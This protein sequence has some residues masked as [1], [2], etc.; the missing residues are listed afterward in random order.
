M[1]F[2]SRIRVKDDATGIGV[3]TRAITEGAETRHIQRIQLDSRINSPMERYRMSFDIAGTAA[4]G[5]GIAAFR[6]LSANPNVYIHRFAVGEYHAAVSSA[7]T[8]LFLK[9]ANSVASGSL[10]AATDIPKFD[11][12]AGNATLEVR[13]GAFTSTVVGNPIAVFN[14]TPTLAAGGGSM[15]S[16][17][18]ESGG[19]L[20]RA[21]KL[22]GDEG[23]VLYQYVA[24]DTDNRFLITVEWE[25]ES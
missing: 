5:A 18:F 11:T 10:I 21:I 17:G 24:G 8:P 1:P 7:V 23:L 13:F 25:E 6:K 9:R 22:T 15:E 16:F 3:A 4:A 19:D 14:W 20:G 12:T 2:E